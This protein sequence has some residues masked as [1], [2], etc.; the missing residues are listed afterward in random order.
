M[1]ALF[2]PLKIAA[3]KFARKTRPQGRA[4]KGTL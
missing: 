1:I 2:V 3:K 4:G